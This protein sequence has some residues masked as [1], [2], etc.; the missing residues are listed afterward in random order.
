MHL[1]DGAAAADVGAIERDVAVEATGP[2]QRR[3]EDV[4]TVGGGDDDDVGGGLEAVHLD[5]QLVEGLLALVVAA[6]QAGAT[7]AAN[8]IDLI[9]EHDAG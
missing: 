3:V 5:Q 6:A 9:D 8:R 2:Q 7:L 4:G 1:E